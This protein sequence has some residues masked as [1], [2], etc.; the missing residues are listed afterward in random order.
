[1]TERTFS[2]KT[3]FSMMA[4]LLIPIA[5]AINFVG[6]QIAGILNLPIFLDVIGTILVAMLCGPWVG[7]VAGVATNLILG[8]TRPTMIPFALVNLVVGLSIGFFARYGWLALN[9]SVGKI[10]WKW[11]VS[12]GVMTIISVLTSAPIVVF[13]FGGLT[14]GGSGLV[15]AA[16]LQAGANLWNA[17]LTGA[18]LTTS[19][20]R[21]LAAI[22]AILIIKVI[23]AR[24][25]TKFS[26]GEY[27]IKETG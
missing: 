6:G 26:L 16:F 8:I 22:F 21:I 15:T 1:M 4:L 18:I 20:D 12:I 13:V 25:L 3:D 11:V 27:Y 2:I 10:W 9:D 14:G 24:T 5:V 17:V 19:A 23:P 7:G